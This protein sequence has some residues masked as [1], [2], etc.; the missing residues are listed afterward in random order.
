[1]N[2]SRTIVQTC[3]YDEHGASVDM[4]EPLIELLLLSRESSLSNAVCIFEDFKRLFDINSAIIKQFL[5]SSFIETEMTSSITTF[6]MTPREKVF[7]FGSNSRQYSE[8]KIREKFEQERSE[9]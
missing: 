5:Q 3:L 2:T 1:M 6:L 7:V 4:L 8:D 9:K